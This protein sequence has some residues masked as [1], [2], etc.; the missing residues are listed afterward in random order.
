MDTNEL[1]RQIGLIKAKEVENVELA[2]RNSRKNQQIAMDNWAMSNAKFRIGDIICSHDV[3]IRIERI[4]G[5]YPIFG[6]PYIEYYGPA[7]TKQL[8]ER[9]DGWKTTI[10]DDSPDRNIHKIP[11]KK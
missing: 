8:K 11:E 4:S 2:R 3:I 5:R 6:E 9:K 7:L 1:K 10:Y